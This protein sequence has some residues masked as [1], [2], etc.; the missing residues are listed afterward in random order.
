MNNDNNNNDNDDDKMIDKQDF[1]QMYRLRGEREETVS[2]ITTEYKK[3]VQE[4]NKN[5]RHDHVAK[6]VHWNLC[7]NYDLQCKET[8]Y[9]Y[10]PEGVMENDQVQLLWDFRVQTAITI[11]NITCPIQFIHSF[12]F[13]YSFIFSINQK[14]KNSIQKFIIH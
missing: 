12:V 13:I 6:V 14:Y 4:Q 2:H 3:L 5:W 9:N 10:S 8:Q 11:K 7:R 1:S